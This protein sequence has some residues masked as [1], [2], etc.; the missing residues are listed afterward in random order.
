MSPIKIS[1]V[2]DISFA[3]AFSE[4]PDPRILSAV[5]PVFSQSDLV[6]GNLENPLLDEGDPVANKC[7][8]R[9][10]REWAQI[11]KG[12]KIQVLSLANNHMMDYGEPGLFSTI[13]ALKENQLMYLGAGRNKEEANAPGFITLYE[14]KI[15]LL[16]RSSVIVSSPSYAEE[17]RAGVAFFHKDETLTQIKNCRKEA[18]F[19]ILILH[20]G[21]ENYEYPTPQQRKLAGELVEAGVDLIIGHHPHVLQGIE[22]IKH[23]MVSYSLGNFVF[24]DFEWTFT[25]QDNR[26]RTKQM[27]L[28]PLQREGMVVQFELNKESPVQYHAMF[29]RIDENGRIAI[30]GGTKR[31]DKF[32]RLSQKLGSG[33][34]QTWWRLYALKQE[35]K[36][37]ILPA[38]RSKKNLMKIWKI[39]PRHLKEFF[40]S[41]LRS[42]RIA[43]GKSTN[44]YE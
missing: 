35:W 22:R 13:E 5:S 31:E 10:I 19:V 18:D 33:F 12:A 7:T 36:M 39:R 28:S 27:K 4:N 37:R 38:L 44:P 42:S 9:G 24:N 16:A 21:V 17:N 43:S 32:A 20:W 26:R 15:A 23:G 41:F 29:T 2:G 34:Y 11:L 30:G 3:G 25:D 40:N 1:A 6:I 14:K 8:L